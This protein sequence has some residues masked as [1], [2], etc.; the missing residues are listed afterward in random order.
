MN[1]SEIEERVKYITNSQG[2]K[3]EV[4]IPIELWQN[5]LDIAN[6]G[7][8]SSTVSGLDPV[9]ENE[10]N[11]EILAD[12]QEAMRSV[13]AGVTYPISQLWDDLES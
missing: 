10:P 13:K 11:A 2:E 4:V 3:T 6:L 8:K 9:D 7:N 1:V 5:L 12:I